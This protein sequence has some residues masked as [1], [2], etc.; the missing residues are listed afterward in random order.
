M[1][2]VVNTLCQAL[3]PKQARST[4][5]SPIKKA[6]L[7]GTYMKQL[8]ELKQLRDSGILEQDE[9]EEQRLDIIKLMRKLNQN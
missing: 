9:Y 7:R 4:C 1:M 6:E 2:T 3:V 8:T 5:S